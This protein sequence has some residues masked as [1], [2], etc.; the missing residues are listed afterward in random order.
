MTVPFARPN[1][2]PAPSVS[3]EPGTNNTAA[4][5]YAAANSTAPQGPIP[6]THSRNDASVSRS[7]MPHAISGPLPLSEGFAD[8]L[9]CR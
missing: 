1:T 6:C 2:N 9:E 8:R 5:T 7:S 3:S 4:G